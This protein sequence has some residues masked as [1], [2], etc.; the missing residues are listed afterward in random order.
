[1]DVLFPF[2]DEEN[3]RLILEGDPEYG[4]IPEE[5]REKVFRMAWDAGVSAARDFL[6]R[7][8]PP[9]DFFSIVRK[10]G[11]RIT[12]SGEDNVSA[13]VRYYSEFY[14]KLKQICLYNGSIRLWCAANGL[15]MTNGR[16][17]ILAHEYFHY[18]EHA[19]LG[20]TSERYQVPAIR[21]GRWS[22][23]KVGCPSLSEI[24]A[25][26]FAFTCFPGILMDEEEEAVAGEGGSPADDGRYDG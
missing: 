16:M 22:F 9:L 15:S 18:L 24:A 12:E 17:L 19:E 25:N 11:I 6:R 5:D 23:G 10:E 3:S 4:K 1:M 14:P 20:W 13:G 2:P 8:E 26:A 7:H 21:I